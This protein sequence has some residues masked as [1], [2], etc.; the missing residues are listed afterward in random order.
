MDLTSIHLLTF[1]FVREINRFSLDL[2]FKTKSS[3]LL[4]T[5]N[6]CRTMAGNGFA[7]EIL[8][9]LL[10]LKS[11]CFG[12]WILKPLSVSS[13]AAFHHSDFVVVFDCLSCFRGKHRPYRMGT[14]TMSIPSSMQVP[15][16]KQKKHRV[17]KPGL[18][19]G[20]MQVYLNPP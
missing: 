7:S 14:S 19:C 6:R 8:S 3:I 10:P 12:L 13:P 18:S 17:I 20:W 9:S 4:N 11:A 5:T 2:C 15:V 1:A 16:D